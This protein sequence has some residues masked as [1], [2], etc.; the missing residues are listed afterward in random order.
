MKTLA[1]SLGPELMKQIAA[2]APPLPPPEHDLS[3]LTGVQF[4]QALV[5]S[6]EYRESIHR[7]LLLD[8]LPPAVECRIL[9]QAWG[10]APQRL[11]HAGPD[12]GPIQIAEVRRVIIRP[13]LTEEH[14]SVH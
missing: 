2:S 8:E 14:E 3:E 11:E 5:D 1:D 4:C 7:R 9:D 12:G 13:K 6:R 10:R